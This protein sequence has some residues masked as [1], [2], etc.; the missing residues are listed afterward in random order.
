MGQREPPHQRGQI[1]ATGQRI[2]F[3]FSMLA[4]VI[5]TFLL[6][7]PGTNASGCTISFENCW[8]WGLS[9]NQYYA[10]LF[11]VIF[12]LTIPIFWLKELDSS[13]VPQHTWEHYTQGI[14]KTMQNLTTFYL[15]IFVIGSQGLTNFT[16]NANITLQYY[17]IQLTNFQAGIDT[18]TSYGALVVAI[19]IFQRY[20]IHRNWRYTQY[21]STTMAASLGLVWILA[22]YDVGGLMDPWFTIFI[23]LDTVSRGNMN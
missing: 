22:Y 5:Q 1:L 9:V 11:V 20:L 17:V 15:L 2:R 13:H 18:V 21:A 12:I 6:N 7:G 19:Y 10:V 14:W 3:T 16:N 8:A 4:G 23:D